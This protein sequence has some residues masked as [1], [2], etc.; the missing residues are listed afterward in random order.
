[1]N[2]DYHIEVVY[3][4]KILCK[5]LGQDYKILKIIRLYGGAQK[6]TYKIECNKGFFSIL[7]IWDNSMNYFNCKINDNDIFESSGADLFELNNK[8]LTQNGIRTPKIY[9]IDRSKKDYSFDFALVEY[10]AGGDIE[11]YFYADEETK[12]KVFTDLNENIKKMHSI[13]NK[14]YGNLKAERAL[15]SRSEEILLIRSIK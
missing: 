5:S 4:Q 7:Y 6:V 10:T 3:L 14:F 12:Y 2:K 1:M 11:K 13:K 15:G 9:Y 8:F